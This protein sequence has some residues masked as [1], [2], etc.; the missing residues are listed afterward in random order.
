MLSKQID[1]MLSKMELAESANKNADVDGTAGS[2][3]CLRYDSEQLSAIRPC[4]RCSKALHIVWPKIQ[5]QKNPRAPLVAPK[6]DWECLR[7]AVC[8]AFVPMI[9]IPDEGP[10]FCSAE[11]GPD[12]GGGGG[13]SSAEDER[14]GRQGME[15]QVETQTPHQRTDRQGE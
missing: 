1:Q 5:P 11:Q 8:G 15:S 14:Q 10:F 7:L 6:F 3:A 13:F 12:E 2:A 9:F 4:L